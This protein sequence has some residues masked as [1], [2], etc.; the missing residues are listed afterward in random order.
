[1]VLHISDQLKRNS[2][3]VWPK[4]YTINLRK[5]M[6]TKIQPRKKVQFLSLKINIPF[7]TNIVYIHILYT[8]VHTYTYIE[9]TEHPP[10][11]I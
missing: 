8:Y 5:K 11:I 6:L 9:R 2:K 4:S 7:E 1:M 3:N 10:L